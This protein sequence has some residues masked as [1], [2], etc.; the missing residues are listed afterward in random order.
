MNATQAHYIIFMF[1]K[2]FDPNV[3]SI[4]LIDIIIDLLDYFLYNSVA[5]ILTF[6]DIVNTLVPPGSIS[7]IIL[8][9]SNHYPI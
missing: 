2:V 9:R 8:N 1:M 5:Y 3:K 4:T 7:P 6:T